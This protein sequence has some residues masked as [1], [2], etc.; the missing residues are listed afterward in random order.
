MGKAAKAITKPFKNIVK[1]VTKP[2]RWA[3]GL[4]DQKKQSKII[5]GQNQAIQAQ[6]QEILNNQQQAMASP[7]PPSVEQVQQATNQVQ[8]SAVRAEKRRKRIATS[9]ASAT[10]AGLTN[11]S[12]SA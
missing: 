8:A 7:P 1:A 11:L 6:Q 9:L 5:Q 10:N 3:L 12:M 2:G 4:T